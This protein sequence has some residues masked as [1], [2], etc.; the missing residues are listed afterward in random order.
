MDKN[1]KFEQNI[2]KEWNVIVFVYEGQV[3]IGPEKTQAETNACVTFQKDEQDGLIS[4]ETGDSAAKFLI[5]GGQPLN[6][7]VVQYG[8]FVLS[9]EN[10]LKKT[11]GEYYAGQNGFEGAPR[12]KSKIRNLKRK[13]I[14]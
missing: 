7:K 12:W 10:D 6:E 2:P 11:F 14:S 1:S 9:S 4:V 8:P 3:S 13:T 5:L